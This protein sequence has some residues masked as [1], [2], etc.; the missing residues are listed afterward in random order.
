KEGDENSQIARIIKAVG[1]RS[2]IQKS[3]MA[4]LRHNTTIAPDEITAANIEHYLEVAE[5]KR[6]G[7]KETS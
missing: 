4:G 2:R 3:V 5:Q 6:I 1:D 7:K